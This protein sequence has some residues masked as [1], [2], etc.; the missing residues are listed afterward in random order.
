MPTYA[1]ADLAFER[2]EGPY[3]F[4]TDGRRYLDFGAGVAVNALGHAHPRL[5]AALTAQAEKLW[6]C[7]NLYRVPGQERVA[8]KLIDN[9]FAETVFFCNSGA[10]AMEGVIKMM[11]KYHDATGQPDRD[12]VIVMEGAFHG[13]TLATLAAGGQEKHLKGFEPVV[14]GFDRV[15]F[16]NMNMLR[17]AI[18]PTTAG[19]LLEPIQGEGGIRPAEIDFLRQTRAAADEFGLL[20]GF[21]E[22]QTGI[23]R[24]GKLFAHQ[25]AD[26]APDIVGAA[27][28]LGG[29]FPVGAVLAT[30]KAAVGM[31][32]GSHGSTFGGNP[33]AMAAAGTVLDVVLEDGFLD[34]VRSI[35]ALLRAEL[36]MLA[37]AHGAVI[38]AV[39]GAGLMLG[40]KCKPLNTKVVAALLGNGLLTVGAGDNVVRLLPPLIIDEPHVRE[41]VAILDRTFRELA[42]AA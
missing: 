29:G 20:L 8:A 22:V 21:D 10:E 41:A 33:L 11:R 9:S 35:G 34:H 15:P 12:R 7:S 37:A 18:G 6:H 1:R 39:R 17:Q 3:L 24:T 16:G 4:A 23:G 38:E 30:A 40:L 32:P 5:V 19:I 42:I 2:G 31:V 13:R 26:I 14:D 25:W 28:G 27:K 36:D